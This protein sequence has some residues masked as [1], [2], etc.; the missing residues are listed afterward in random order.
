MG[1]PMKPTNEH[2]PNHTDILTGTGIDLREEEAYSQSQFTFSQN[3]TGTQS[4][5]LSNKIYSPYVAGPAEALYG[6][7][8]ASQP[9]EHPGEISQEEWERK[10]AEEAWHVAAERMALSRQAELA[11]PFSLPKIMQEKMRKTVQHSGL[12]MNFSRAGDMGPLKTY[13]YKDLQASAATRAS[14]GQA[15]IVTNGTALPQSALVVDQL[16]LLSLATKQRTEQLLEEVV[17]LARGRQ[18]GSSGF[19]SPEWIDSAVPANAADGTI[20]STEPEAPR[21][22]WE[23]AVSPRT[24]PL[25]RKFI[26][27]FLYSVY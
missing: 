2:D 5:A 14:N 13:M 6:S 11:N 27:Q 18:T 12:R 8:L 4:M 24:N 15:M 10:V 23:S 17:R 19:V 1:P 3:A 21:I 9:A 20:V 7:G 26:I 16:I 22:G 25:K